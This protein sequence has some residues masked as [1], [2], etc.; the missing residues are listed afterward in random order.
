MNTELYKSAVEAVLFAVG[1]PVAADKI[2]DAL[3]V[4]AK[5]VTALIEELKNEYDDGERGLVIL[6]FDDRYQMATQPVFAD[7]V[8]R[9]LDNRRN[10]PLSQAALEVLSIVAYNQPVS[11]SFIDQI[12]VVDSSSPV[13]SLLAKNLICEAG[14][15]ELP[16]RPVSFKTTDN[17]LRCFGLAS[18]AQLPPVYSEALELSTEDPVRAEDGGLFSE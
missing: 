11:R 5:T 2:A 3:A 14:R 7:F 12:R 6:R 10:T 17:F 4:D 16:G 13:A 8:T 9:A 1:E 18:T 15:L